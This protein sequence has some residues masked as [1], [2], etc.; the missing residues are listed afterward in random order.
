LHKFDK[1]ISPAME[2]LMSMEQSILCNIIRNADFHIESFL[3]LKSVYFTNAFNR[4]LFQIIKDTNDKYHCVDVLI[5]QRKLNAGSDTD[6]LL[7]LEQILAKPNLDENQ[8]KGYCDFLIQHYRKN[9]L[10]QIG[11]DI[12]EF[13]E[14][15]TFIERN[16]LVPF[17]K[18]MDILFTP[19][20]PTGT[21]PISV[22]IDKFLISCKS[23][24]NHI[25]KTKWKQFNSAFYGLYRGQVTVV[26]ARPGMGVTAF[27]LN[28]LMDTATSEELNYLIGIN[29]TGP[30]ISARMMSKVSG[31]STEMIYLAEHMSDHTLKRLIETRSVLDTMNLAFEFKAQTS[32]FELEN[33][34]RVKTAQQKTKIVAIDKIQYVYLADKNKYMTRER[35]IGVIM[36]RLKSLAV[37]LNVCMLLASSVSRSAEHRG[38]TARPMLYDL[39]DSGSIEEYA[40][41]V[42]F[43]YRPEYYGLCEMEDGSPAHTK[44]EVILAKSKNRLSGTCLLQFI[45]KNSL[46][47]DFPSSDEYDAENKFFSKE[48]FDKL[49]E[50]SEEF[51]GE[52]PF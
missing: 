33:L 35:E 52:F 24:E 30:Q 27:I 46:I 43:L 2:E 39:K 37:E 6:N 23:P 7:I 11:N 8:I 42:I 18:R 49:I 25:I 13:C 50:D 10:R 44:M 45:G 47:Q 20:V 38:N 4:N 22:L 29:E 41:N 51:K 16:E 5:L 17:M 3:R 34:I 32:L 12:I 31:V 28:L 36:Q 9:Q 19:G 21:L 15:K 1:I 48:V 40:N 14:E 26:A